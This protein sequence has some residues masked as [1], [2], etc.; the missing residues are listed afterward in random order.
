MS[1]VDAALDYA[2]K[3]IPVFPVDP[4]SKRPLI[5]HGFLDATVDQQQI[6]AWWK[7]WP[8][9]MIGVPTGAASG[10]WILDSDI[11]P[12]KGIDGPKSLAELIGKHGAL[13][14]TLTSATP[15]GGAHY[16]WLWNGVK[17][18]NSYSKIGPGL[19]VRGDGGY[20]IVPPSVRAD[21]AIYQWSKNVST[22]E[23][24][25]WL[26]DAALGKESK[27]KTWARK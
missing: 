5:T 8:K 22:V 1:I 13:P 15:R 9:A 7:Q 18:R 3:N 16:W 10:V 17:I 11:D 12:V 14:D 21:G 2:K 25:V 6:C 4:A 26:V 23:A 24:P 19:D 20:V 27:T